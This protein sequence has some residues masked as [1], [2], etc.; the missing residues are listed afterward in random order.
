M[1][2]NQSR[3][4]M[5][6]PFEFTEAAWTTASS[7]KCFIL[8]IPPAVQSRAELLR[9]VAH[10]GEF[11]DYFG[12]TWDALLDCLRDFNWIEQRQIVVA[13]ADLPLLARPDDC[14]IYVEI[15]R[16]ACLDWS[17]LNPSDPQ[18][19]LRVRFPRSAQSPVLTMLG[20]QPQHD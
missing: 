13:H 2:D 18:H 4:A 9:V 3:A 20:L 16:E 1:G 5:K 8:D 14:R 10:H 19:Q 11:P 7:D 15:L 17:R 12:H 6:C